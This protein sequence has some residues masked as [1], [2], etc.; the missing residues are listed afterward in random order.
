MGANIIIPMHH[1]FTNKILCGMSTEPLNVL[2][3]AQKGGLA[4]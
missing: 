2:T 3:D 4:S 1:K